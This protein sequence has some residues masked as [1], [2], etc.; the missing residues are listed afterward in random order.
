MTVRVRMAPSPTGP[1]HIGTARAALFNY[2]YARQQKGYFLLRI[3]DTDRERSDLQ[4][5]KDVTEQLS[6]L[7]ITW[8]NFFRQSERLSLYKNSLEKL[9]TEGK[10]FFCSHSINELAK[11]RQEQMQ[12]K[13]AP[14]HLCLY[15]NEGLK[16]GILRFKNE[17]QGAVAFH[18]LIRGEISIQAGIL[19]DFSVAKSL[20][21]ALYNFT[22]VVDDGLEHIT[23]IIRGEDHIPNTPK[24]ILLSRALGFKEPLYAHLPLVLGKDRSKLSKRHGSTAVS[25]YRQEGYLP[26]ALVNF[27]GLLGWHPPES[28]GTEE[29]FG[30]EDMVR[31]FSFEGVQKGGAIFDEEKLLWLNGVYIRKT[32][33]HTLAGILAEYLKPV[34]HK[35][36]K[37]NLEWWKGIVLLEQSRLSRLSEIGER[38]DYFFEEPLVKKDILIDTLPDVERIIKHL[39]H[40]MEIIS[41]CDGKN[42]SREIVESYIMPYATLE[43]KK[44]VLWPFRVALTGRRASPGLFEV[45]ELLGKEAVLRRLENALSLLSS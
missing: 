43:G 17:H 26:E 15:R 12:K 39:A 20:D 30:I 24:Q 14:H 6:W 32:N 41:G 27:L 29:L 22:T 13:E 42:F 45:A 28:L 3:D 25:Q 23:H 31:H 9:L 1:L 44:E 5:E 36:A 33:I 16:E 40:I 38:V 10:I 19:G 2:I 37:Q 18:D 35:R 7:G 8:D 4:F 34:W 21:V 11:E